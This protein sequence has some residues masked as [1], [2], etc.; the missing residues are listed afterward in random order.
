MR[1]F[2]SIRTFVPVDYEAHTVRKRNVIAHFPKAEHQTSPTLDLE[3][4]FPGNDKLQEK[5]K[6]FLSRLTPESSEL[7]TSSLDG[8]SV[9]EQVSETPADTPPRN[10]G[11]QAKVLNNLRKLNRYY[12]TQ[13]NMEIPLQASTLKSLKKMYQKDAG[14][15]S[16]SPE[17]VEDENEAKEFLSRLTEP[18][19]ELI[20][21]HLA[22]LSPELQ[23]KFL[24][25]L[26]NL[27]K[28]TLK[29]PGEEIHVQPSTLDELRKNLL[30][31][32]DGDELT[33]LTST[34]PDQEHQEM[35]KAFLDSLTKKSQ[36]LV[37]DQLAKVD[38]EDLGELIEAL[39]KLVEPSEGKPSGKRVLTPKALKKAIKQYEEEK[40]KPNL[41][42]DKMFADDPE[43]KQ[44]AGIFLQALT[45]DSLD[46]VRRHFRGLDLDQQARILTYLTDLS[47]KLKGKPGVDLVVTPDT[48]KEVVKMDDEKP[49]GPKSRKLPA[50]VMENISPSNQEKVRDFWSTLCQ[51]SKDLAIDYLGK[52]PRKQQ[53]QFLLN[54]IELNGKG[55]EAEVCPDSFEKAVP[56]EA[57]PRAVTKAA[58]A[59]P[60]EVTTDNWAIT[61]PTPKTTTKN[62]V[63]VTSTETPT[64]TEETEVSENCTTTTEVTTTTTTE[65]PSTTQAQTTETATT[66][67]ETETTTVEVTTSTTEATTTEKPA[68]TEASTTTTK[69]TTEVEEMVNDQPHSEES[70]VAEVECPYEIIGLFLEHPEH[71]A[72]VNKFWT[73]LTSKAQM[74]LLDC[75]SGL[76][77]SDKRLALL[78][79]VNLCKQPDEHAAMIDL[80][81]ETIRHI[82][83]LAIPEPA[84]TGNFQIAEQ[85]SVPVNIHSVFQ[86]EQG[87]VDELWKKLTPESQ[88]CLL[89]KLENLSPEGKVQV[90]RHLLSITKNTQVQPGMHIDLDSVML[91]QIVKEA[92]EAEKLAEVP[93][94]I[95]NLFKQPEDQDLIEK[96]WQRLT[97][98]SQGLL[99][100]D[101]EGLS[102]QGKAQVLQRLVNMTKRIENERGM[103]IVLDPNTIGEL[104][105]PEGAEGSPCSQHQEVP[106]EVKCLFDDL[107][108]ELD[109]VTNFWRRLTAMAQNLL[110]DCLG[111]VSSL[112]KRLALLHL[113][114]L[115]DAIEE[116]PCRKIGL[117]ADVV[118]GVV[119]ETAK[120][121]CEVGELPK[122]KVVIAK[123]AGCCEEVPKQTVT[124]T[125]TELAATVPC[126]EATEPP[127]VTTTETLEETTEQVVEKTTT[128]EP[129]Q[130]DQ[131]YDDEVEES[132]EITEGTTEETTEHTTQQL[133]DEWE[134]MQ[135]DQPYTEESE[136]HTEGAPEP[137]T[138]AEETTEQTTEA[139][140]ELETTEVTE[141]TTEETTET[142]TEIDTTEV[143]EWTTE[144]TT[145]ET[146]ELET[147]ETT[148]LL[149]TEVT[150]W[151]TEPTT[152]E[153]TEATSELETTEA[154][155]TT[156]EA[157]TT[158]WTTEPT[159]EETTEAT[160]ELETTEA[161]TEAE[162][163]ELTTESTTEETTEASTEL[164]T[165]EATEATTEAE[166]T[167]W[168][169]EPTTEETTEATT[170]LDT[171][172][173]S[174]ATTEAETTEWTTEPTTEETT[175]ATTELETT[176]A[177]TE[178][179]TTE[180]TTEPTTEETTEATT[181]L[182]TT[183]VT[184][185]TEEITEETTEVAT[186]PETTETTEITEQTTEE[187]T[188]ETTMETTEATTEPTTE[189]ETTEPTEET[190]EQTTELETTEATTTT[191]E[192]HHEDGEVDLDYLLPNNKE[193][194]KKF[195]LF[196]DESDEGTQATLGYIFGSLKTI[197]RKA[198]DELMEIL[199]TDHSNEEKLNEVLQWI[200]RL[201]KDVTESLSIFIP[202][203]EDS[204]ASQGLDLDELLPGNPDLKHKVE[205]LI[206][207]LAPQDQMH[208]QQMLSDLEPLPSENQ[209]QLNH[210]LD[211][212]QGDSSTML[213]E[214]VN[215]MNSL[216]DYITGN[217]QFTTPRAWE[218]EEEVTVLTIH[219]ENIPQEDLRNAWID[220]PRL[221]P[222]NEP[223]QDELRHFIDGLDPTTEESVRYILSRSGTLSPDEEYQLADFLERSRGRPPQVG[224]GQPPRWPSAIAGNCTFTY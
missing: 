216:P 27:S 63:K 181:E 101:M 185:T 215:W 2:I 57:A 171:T 139:T 41:D 157:E 163:T 53:E 71:V 129:M 13:P 125:T 5:M 81:Y 61:F 15:E 192:P 167:E 177:T 184:E 97:P 222:Y 68:V 198:M 218:S 123:P 89:T 172:E 88:N 42:V 26:V 161:T 140:T 51:E 10:A 182:K 128:E 200:N 147:E 213:N 224:T 1:T 47:N 45:K 17:S 201:P 141:T 208:L 73:R 72:P 180:W 91:E 50:S 28:E 168:T 132:T 165:T 95:K 77:L 223:L 174:E 84:H 158:E 98:T 135:G 211:Y 86:D 160:T 122:I 36:D 176:E 6:D 212:L 100:K 197:P 107:P 74:Q 220:Y 49:L 196:M 169:T 166:T 30:K 44:R 179:D 112:Q 119:G 102:L 217:R 124:E 175:E 8:A 66:E 93:S 43:R 110:S 190:T 214:M 120:A 60:K 205:D 127:K 56:G 14:V 154:S 87:A 153:T 105:E 65:P 164:K 194:Q 173:A 46:A 48:L 85:G 29:K 76:N 70:E 186:E 35:A 118:K 18:S 99:L 136:E 183:E 11:F 103:H 116:G 20:R 78:H 117:D 219:L 12:L 193:L 150:E 23:V 134:E 133:F 151:T 221:I 22:T 137:S 178:A 96:L 115:N 126:E 104:V 80:D 54:A 152:E 39:S 38:P 113:A 67:Q 34:I 59:K 94:E 204:Q 9:D 106:Y 52:L 199:S 143:T 159:T 145:E 79:L 203:D 146:T 24:D 82:I 90:L 130:G 206:G 83:S 195:R 75:I 16:T 142:S 111:N 55:T 191:E 25:H 62:Q 121:C 170:E 31:K 202:T 131:P 7:L 19:K 32:P 33:N 58:K 69:T 109:F 4:I 21:D 188:T 162:T 207:S 156:T 149:T 92:V 210:F 37:R 209:H 114:R 138:E 108:N 3:K 148:E 187:A 189:L 155:E 64:E 144:P 40:K